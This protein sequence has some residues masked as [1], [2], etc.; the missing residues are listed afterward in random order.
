MPRG[1][2]SAV[3]KL[4]DDEMYYGEFG[5]K[6]L[7]NSDISTLLNNPLMFRKGKSDSKAMLMGRYFHWAILEPEK[8][9]EI[10][11]IDATTR[12]TKLYKDATSDGNMA[13]LCHEQ[14]QVDKMV[15]AINSN[16]DFFDGI[17]EEGNVYEIPEV[18]S[19]NGL[20]WKGKAD[21][22][23]KDK[24]IDLKTTSGI[25]SFRHSAYKY[26]YD[27]QAYIYQTL[28]GLPMEFWVI[29]KSTLAMGMFHCSD[30]FLRSGEQ[31]VKRASEVYNRFFG[32]NANESIENHYIVEEL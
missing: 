3:S 11:C 14:D 23:T 22:I 20:P 25:N 18:G 5:Q 2:M 24:I 7:S 17:Y 27:S 6:W 4:K 10:R 13:L 26:N 12:S 21:I 16:F 28:F 31:K 19:I 29:D 8:A 9:K 32:E 30:E 1:H 15:D